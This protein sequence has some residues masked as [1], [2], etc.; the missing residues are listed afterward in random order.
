MSVY[1]P[2]RDYLRLSGRPQV[3]LTFREIE[4]ILGRPLPASAFRFPACWSNE[5]SGNHVQTQGWMNAG[6]MTVELD[7][8]T[9]KVT[10]LKS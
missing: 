7:L 8:S 1:H 9:R 2:L 6:Y 4:D 10:F 3:R 5:R